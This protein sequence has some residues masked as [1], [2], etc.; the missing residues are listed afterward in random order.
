MT[1]S[2]QLFRLHWKNHSPNFVTVFSQL[3]NTESLVD[4]TL[5]CDGKQ[6]QAHRVVLSACSNY[7][8]ELFVSHPCQHP[9]VLLKDIRYEDLHTVIHFMY[10]GEVNI[11]HDQLNSI[12]KTAEVLHV[13]GFADVADKESFSAALLTQQTRSLDNFPES[14]Q[15]SEQSQ[16]HPEESA[17]AAKRKRQRHGSGSIQLKSG[18][19]DQ[20]SPNSPLQKRQSFQSSKQATDLSTRSSSSLDSTSVIKSQSSLAGQSSV[21]SNVDMEYFP[22][23]SDPK[24]PPISSTGS[25]DTAT[26]MMEN[27]APCGLPLS[28]QK[29][30]RTLMRQDCVTRKESDKDAIGGGESERASPIVHT[31]QP[32]LPKILKSNSETELT[33]S[34][35]RSQNTTYLQ[36]PPRPSVPQVIGQR[37]QPIQPRPSVSIE[38]MHTVTEPPTS[39]PPTL[40]RASSCIGGTATDTLQVPCFTVDSVPSSSSHS[41]PKLRV[42]AEENLRRSISNP[43]VSS[44]PPVSTPSTNGHCPVL[45]TGAALGCNYCWNTNDSHGRILRRKTK[46]HCPDCQA[47]LCIVPC[48]QE[49]HEKYVSSSGETKTSGSQQK[50][51]NTSHQMFKMSSF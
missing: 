9:I 7:F 2:Q 21:E 18:P 50:G 8:Q 32:I 20:P 26:A 29:R 25:L 16:E 40:T 42:K 48:F 30:T 44:S 3:L 4:V 51:S 38:E 14:Q 34:R 10:Y 35:P 1:T 43:G 13:K 19:Q 45:R 17:S 6:I 31:F 24:P 22:K 12:L 5:A 47:N 33:D 11:K 15:Q 41:S 49:Y 28:K 23:E 37:S 27:G 36:V 39:T 46:Y